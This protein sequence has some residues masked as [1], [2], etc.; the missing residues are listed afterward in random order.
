MITA[1]TTLGGSVKK[2]SN[3][4]VFMSAGKEVKP[5]NAPKNNTN[6][7]Q[8][9]NNN[10]N[11]G[12]SGVSTSVGNTGSTSTSN[13]Y[14][15]QLSAMYAQQQ[16]AA[17]A[18]AAAQRAAAENAY[19]NNRSALE[20]AFNTKVGALKSNYDSTLGQLGNAYSSSKGAVE[21]DAAKS[22]REAYINKMMSSKNLSQ[23][24]SAQGLSGGA[25][26]TTLA[27]MQNNYGNARNNIN[28]TLNDN[29]TSLENTY[30]GNLASALQA[31]NTNL[32]NAQSERAQYMAQLESDLANLTAN[33]YGNQYNNFSA[34]SS[35]YMSALQKAMEQQQAYEY[36]ASLANNKA[37]KVNTSQGTSMDS[38]ESNYSKWLSYAQKLA[39]SGYSADDITADLV[40][41]TEANMSTINQILSQL[42]G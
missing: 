42:A 9:T 24:L 18:A 8:Q 4:T 14:Q 16:A 15:Q 2:A 20:G 17:Q 31:Y 40:S 5:N 39:G 25:A 33:S 7:V 11:S 38:A 19:N 1:G 21:N 13:T 41:N 26:E 23:Q 10:S 32:A 34:L 6:T 3:G 22:L 36:E 37:A 35:D 29:I 30:Q 28:T 12:V 27:G